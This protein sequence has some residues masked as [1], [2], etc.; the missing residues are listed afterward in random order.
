MSRLL[1]GLSAA[2]LVAAAAGAAPAIG[3]PREPGPGHVVVA[4]P[5]WGVPPPQPPL[6]EPDWG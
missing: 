3:D 4:E 5:D 2:A 6:R 1:V